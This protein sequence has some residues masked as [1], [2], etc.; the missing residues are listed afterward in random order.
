MKPQPQTGRSISEIVGE[1]R[2][3]LPASDYREQSLR[4][5][6]LICAKCAREFEPRT[7]ICSPSTT[8]TATTAT[9]RPTARTGESLRLLPRRRAQPRRPRGVLP[10]SPGMR[11]ITSLRNHALR[12][13]RDLRDPGVRREN[14]PRRRRGRQPPARGA[15][16]GSRPRPGLPRRA[17]PA[18]AGLRG[19]G[20]APRGRRGRGHWEC[21]SVGGEL[22]ERAAHTENPQGV[23]AVF[24]RAGSISRRRSPATGRYSCSIGSRPRQSWSHPEDR[25][26][27]RLRRSGRLTG[28]VDP[29]NPKCVRPARGASSGCRSRTPISLP[30]PR[31]WRPMGGACTRPRP[32]AA[33]STPPRNSPGGSGCS[34]PGGRGARAGAARALRGPAHPDRKGRIAQR[35]DGR[36]RPPL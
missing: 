20:G 5:H 4:I 21:F 12:R 9:T 6:G 28:T 26:G 34:R 17:R 16:L 24:S 27:R 3:N 15:H 29:L 10:Q 22:L 7:G 13:Y 14:R 1:L 23:L 32:T 31:Q 36:G 30:R 8:R 2:Q 18:P 33:S 19:A 11:E 35:G 25:R